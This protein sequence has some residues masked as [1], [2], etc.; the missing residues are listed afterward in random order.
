MATIELNDDN[1]RK[2]YQE[3]DIVIIDFWAIWCGPCHA[4]AETYEEVSEEFPDIIFGK[5]NT[6]E[7][8]KL[9]QHFSVRSIPTL[10]IIRE[11]LEVF[12]RPGGMSSG[13]LREVIRHVQSL[14][15]DDVRK[16]IEEEE[17]SNT[18]S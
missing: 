11:Q 9:A 13:D 5:V 2:I 8:M 1:F 16:K 14:D 18:N 10:M 3:N 12:Y 4:F 7:E 6:E 17:A 15:M